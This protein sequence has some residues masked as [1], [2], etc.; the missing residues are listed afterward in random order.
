MRIFPALSILAA[1][2]LSA[3]QSGQSKSASLG[4]AGFCDRL[5]G[6]RSVEGDADTKR[7]VTRPEMCALSQPGALWFKSKQV[8]TRLRGREYWLLVPPSD[9]HLGGSAITGWDL[10]VR[11]FSY[12]HEYY[13]VRND[14]ARLQPA[15]AQNDCP[16]KAVG[17]DWVEGGTR[18]CLTN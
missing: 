2:A 17:L 8:S 1:L 11:P 14:G 15:I 6:W 12:A 16:R 5:T 18:Y 9:P 13:L 10:Q 7:A 3:C 4:A